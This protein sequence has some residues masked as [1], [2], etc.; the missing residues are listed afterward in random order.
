MSFA[1][2]HNVQRQKQEKP[3]K[4]SVWSV[5]FLTMVLAAAVPVQGQNQPG[6]PTPQQLAQQAEM[7]QR[8]AM[9]ESIVT[10]DEAALGRKFDPHFRTT[11]LKSLTAMSIVDMQQIATGSAASATV[12]ILG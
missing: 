9:A 5:L 3:M 6:P 12:D 7:M 11:I 1:T 10:R 8:Q 2:S 4:T